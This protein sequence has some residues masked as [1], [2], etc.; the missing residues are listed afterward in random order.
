MAVKRSSRPEGLVIATLTGPSVADQRELGG[1]DAPECLA[2][3]KSGS[4]VVKVASRM[5]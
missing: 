2:W 1:T 5:T 3:M 4:T